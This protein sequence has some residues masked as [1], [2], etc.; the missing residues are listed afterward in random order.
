[1]TKEELFKKYSVD[2][3]HSV[4]DSS[5]DQWFSI[6]IFRVMHDGR[7]PGENDLSLK[8]IVDF[9]DKFKKDTKFLHEMMKKESW[10]SFYLTAKRSVYRYADILLKE[11]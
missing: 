1:M 10:G 2:E 9:L 8:Y 6:E 5:I 3:T 11:L 4:W 7:L